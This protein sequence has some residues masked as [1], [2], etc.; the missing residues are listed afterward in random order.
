MK[1]FAV[2]GAGFGDEGKGMVVSTLCQQHPDA[3]VVRYCGGQQAGH[4]VILRNGLEHVFSNFGS[5]TL[6]GNSTYWS[7]H[8]TVDPVGIINELDILLEKGIYPTLFLNEICPVT[9]PFDIA[10]N[11]YLEKTNKHGSCGVGVGQTIQ[12]QKDHYS[13]KI[14]DLLY[15]SV[16]KIK[17]DMIKNYYLQWNFENTDIQ[18]FLDCSVAL[19]RSKHI[20]TVGARPHYNTLIFEGSQGLLL[21][22]HY[23][24]FPHVTRANTGT[25]NILNHLRSNNVR[26]PNNLQIYLVTR[27]YQTRHGNGP[28]TNKPSKKW[29]NPY[30]QQLINGWQGEWRT[31]VLD[32][33]LLKYAMHSDWFI[34]QGR[35]ISLVVTC[36]D[37]MKGEW[38]FTEGGDLFKSPSESRFIEQIH[39]FLEIE[40]VLLSYD[41]FPGL[42]EF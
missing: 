7:S 28:M 19:V 30:E 15:P 42:E 21:D 39:S 23:G 41:P 24:F 25:V 4:H 6:Q 20:K 11:Q 34:K 26:R 12:R 18:E 10:Y 38:N 5:G 31:S 16:L 8:C 2:I 22:Q 9:T 14:I 32:I 33:D 13:L 40:N 17:M 27:A 1:N 3:L 35:N 37:L 36:L 29:K